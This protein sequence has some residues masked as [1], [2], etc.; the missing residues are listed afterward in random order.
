MNSLGEDRGQR[1]ILNTT[2]GNVVSKTRSD[3]IACRTDELQGG[4]NLIQRKKRNL[5]QENLKGKA[6]KGRTGPSSGPWFKQPLNSDKQ[7]VFVRQPE[8]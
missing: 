2:R 6:T 1:N 7:S 4:Q 5:D 3:D 8:H